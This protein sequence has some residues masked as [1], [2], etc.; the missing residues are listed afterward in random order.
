MLEGL[1]Y[2]QETIGIRKEDIIN[3]PCETNSL[4]LEDILLA[5]GYN[6]RREP[7]VKAISNGDVQWEIACNGEQ[8]F[9][10]LV[11]GFG[12][13]FINGDSLEKASKY[14][15]EHSFPFIVVT[16]GNWLSV[17][18]SSMDSTAH[19][20]N[21]IYDDSAIDELKALSKDEYNITKLFEPKDKEVKTAE[22]H[23][24]EI[25]KLNSIIADLE[26]KVDSL[27]SEKKQLEDKLDS[28]QSDL[29]VILKEKEE[30]QGKLSELSNQALTNDNTDEIS[31][32][33]LEI[34]KLNTEIGRLET[35]LKDITT[36]RDELKE[37]LVK[38]P[39]VSNDT[40]NQYQELVEQLR[41]ENEALKAEKNDF[42][43]GNKFET[44]SAYRQRIAE[45]VEDNQK[46]I[47]EITVLKEK[48]EELE[49]KASG[50]EEEKV[51]MA[52]QL[53]E[54]VEDN[55]KLPRT[56]VG[57]VESRLFQVM[58]LNKFVGICLQELFNAVQY[59]L[60]PILFDG[61]MFKIVQPAVRKDLMI[62][63]N[64]YDI[65]LSD[66]SE[67]EA[68]AKLKKTFGHFPKVVFMCKSIGDVAN[69]TIVDIGNTQEQE[70][71]TDN[72]YGQQNDN[73]YTEDIAADG[74]EEVQEQETADIKLLGFA[75]I[76]IYSVLNEG[77]S[78]IINL[79]AIGN[80]THNFRIR[81]GTFYDIINDGILALI[82]LTPQ[83][84]QSLMGIKGADLTM[85]S[86][87]IYP[88]PVSE[89]SIQILNTPYFAEVNSI[90][91]C[92]GILYSMAD[93]LHLE[94]T[95]TYMYFSA[96]YDENNRFVDNFLS[97]SSLSLDKQLDLNA[98][99]TCKDNIHGLIGRNGLQLLDGIPG[100]FS[101]G[102]KLF[103]RL[104]AFQSDYNKGAVEKVEALAEMIG[105]ILN[106]NSNMDTDEIIQS[107]NSYIPSEY[108]VISSNEEDI[109][110]GEHATFEVNGITYYIGQMPGYTTMLIL[111][112]LNIMLYPDI[113]LSFR[114][115]LDSTL[116]TI[117]KQGVELSD[118]EEFATSKMLIEAI[119]N[120]T[121]TIAKKK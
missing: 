17:Y 44:E 86:Q 79:E 58:E 51:A 11:L 77:N 4:L 120:N 37:K 39:S 111:Y 32:L 55:T 80:Q 74:E 100:I 76:D 113:K 19:K 64:A 92:I 104:F 119:G 72:I 116:Y 34:E 52:R 9:V 15:L 95:D 60:M 87:L 27:K 23:T 121:K 2:V 30:L 42:S 70:R 101:M 18:N 75:M 5:L 89:Q 10:V 98:F 106:Q 94:L 36:E 108:I 53:L 6:K 25:S 114:V 99:E 88:E 115:E 28:T 8:R 105:S 22:A 56:Y 57:V 20:I 48:L 68:I 117:Y 112:Y 49:R 83:I 46:K 93:A 7:G 47:T 96:E 43:K 3:N 35:E 26:G 71:L 40:I 33:N 24:D 103:T 65:D 102:N 66:M 21:N 84:I 16:D 82:S 90:E 81:N 97:Y 1:E 59:D 63:T 107:I 31:R 73:E 69:N 12:T 50:A 62:S 91:D 29:N 61:D 45:L 118:C 54:A 38:V 109:I 14:A 41:Q 110:P 78:G 13:R 85:I 67:L